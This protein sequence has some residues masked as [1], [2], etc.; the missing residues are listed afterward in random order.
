MNKIMSAA[1][2]SIAVLLIGTIATAYQMMPDAEAIK[3]RGTYLKDVG[4]WRKDRAPAKVCGD[5]LCSIGDAS[6]GLRK[7]QIS[8]GHAR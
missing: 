7:G 5:E 3:A 2:F 8:R 1:I 6:I 4:T